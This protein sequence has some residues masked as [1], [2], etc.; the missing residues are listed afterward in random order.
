MTLQEVKTAL[1]EG[2]KVYCQSKRYEV[3]KDSKGQYL[4]HS[5][6]DSNTIGLTWA[7]DTTLN[8]KEENFFIG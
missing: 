4:I 8:D 6:S 1:A 3:I 7:D 2:K 5:Q